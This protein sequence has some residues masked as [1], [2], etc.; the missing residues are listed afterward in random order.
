[1]EPYIRGR[2]GD[3]FVHPLATLSL[4]ATCEI[5]VG[6]DVGAQACPSIIVLALDPKCNTPREISGCLYAFGSAPGCST[7]YERKGSVSERPRRREAADGLRNL[8]IQPGGAVI[9]RQGIG[10][11]DKAA[12]RDDRGPGAH[13][14]SRVLRS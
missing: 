14:K 5:L 6:L 9:G 13:S 8:G 10:E 12:P 4:P 11:A 7:V 3:H 1:V 2:E